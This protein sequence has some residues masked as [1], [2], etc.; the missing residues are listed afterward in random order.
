MT[1][2]I[3]IKIQKNI[4][5]SSTFNKGGQHMQILLFE[6]SQVSLERFFLT[7][8]LDLHFLLFTNHFLV[9]QFKVATRDGYVAVKIFCLS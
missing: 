8:I 4:L 3:E 5:G 1:G 2:D 7:N 9:E 6:W